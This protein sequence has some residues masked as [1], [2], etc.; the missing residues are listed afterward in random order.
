M[1][2]VYDPASSQRMTCIIILFDTVADLDKAV[3]CVWQPCVAV[4]NGPFFVPCSTMS[5]SECSTWQSA[6]HNYT[7]QMSSHSPSRWAASFF[8]HAYPLQTLRA[9]SFHRWESVF[10]S[11]CCSNRGRPVNIQSNTCLFCPGSSVS[12]NGHTDPLMCPRYSKWEDTT[13]SIE[14]HIYI[15]IYI[16]ILYMCIY[17]YISV[18]LII[19]Y[20]YIYHNFLLCLSCYI[21]YKIISTCN[22]FQNVTVYTILHIYMIL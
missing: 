19:I 7:A 6:A 4:H 12:A 20:I 22:N 13:G 3:A 15:Y 21:F 1:L 2:T 10:M 18:C 16:Y 8:Q 11:Y 17:I 9:S 14:V 5:H